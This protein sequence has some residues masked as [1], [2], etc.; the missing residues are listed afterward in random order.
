MPR[1][2]TAAPPPLMRYFREAFITPA[3]PC[4]R[5]MPMRFTRR[6]HYDIAARC[7]RR[8]RCDAFQLISRR[9]RASSPIVA[10][11]PP[12]AACRFFAAD[13]SVRLF[14]DCRRDFRR[15]PRCRSFDAEMPT[16]KPLSGCASAAFRRCR[17]EAMFF[18]AAADFCR[19]RCLYAPPAAAACCRYAII[20]PPQR[21]N[22]VLML[23]MIDNMPPPAF[24]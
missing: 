5:L 22:D 19:R 21:R 8:Y 6:L 20:A 24:P 10:S 18:D 9:R 1:R 23:R 16:Q 11:P 13:A 17:L 4:R 15:L 7:G 2:T 14:F 12:I 3:A